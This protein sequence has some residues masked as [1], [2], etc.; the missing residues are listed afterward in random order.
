MAYKLAVSNNKGGVG[1]TNLVIQLAIFLITVFGLRVRIV[2]LD[3]QGDSS[4]ALKFELEE[5][6]DVDSVLEVIESAYQRRGFITG[7][8][9]RAIQ[10]CRFDV[11]WADKLTFI[12]SRFDL[13]QATHVGPD[14][15]MLLRL[16]A[17]MDGTC[18]DV[19]VVIYDC[20]PNLGLLPKMAWAD[21][22]DVLL[23]SQPS[24]RSLRGLIRTQ[25]EL[26]YSRKSLG[27]PD[28]DIA[29]L[30]VTHYRAPSGAVKR[31]NHAYWLDRIVKHFGEEKPL[32]WGVIPYKARLATLDDELKPIGLLP[33][34]AERTALEAPYLPI[35]KRLHDIALTTVHEEIQ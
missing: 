29:G 12:P 4:A 11:P 22:D 23:V 18:D 16:R 14:V 8:A 9:A 34:S 26:M 19:D 2:D 1:K 21:S 35:V 33:P 27:V 5:E 32:L 15:D 10:K 28:L 3:P 7:T 17:A 25:A 24:F 6:E 20:P 31:N 13:E 30:V